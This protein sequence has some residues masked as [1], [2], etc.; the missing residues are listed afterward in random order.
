MLLGSHRPSFRI[1]HENV[2]AAPPGGGLAMTLAIK[3]R[4]L[5]NHASQI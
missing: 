4:Y 3:L 5:G 2:H 1:R